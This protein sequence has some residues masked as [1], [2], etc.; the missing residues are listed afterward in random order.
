LKEYLDQ[1]YQKWLDTPLPAL[2]GKTP[3]KA[4]ATKEGQ[5]QVENLL[6]S[7]EYHHQSHMKYDTAWIRKELGL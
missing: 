7:M 2:Q 5:R 4:M 1:H 3:R 6:R